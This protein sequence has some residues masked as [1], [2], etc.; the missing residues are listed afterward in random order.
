V[1]KLRDALSP[2]T[3]IVGNGDILSR[4]QGQELAKKYNLDGVMI[5]RGIFQDPYVFAESSPWSK[6][7]EAE[8]KA[9]YAKHVK[10]FA[11]TWQH[12]E[13]RVHTLNK[14]CKMY[15]QDFD[16]AKDLRERLM[17]ASTTDELLELLS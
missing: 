2:S 17:N 1:V 13:R 16:G 10:L 5:G 7:G 8:R 4:K 11:T 3:L 12:D 9:L 14:F 15:I 6:M